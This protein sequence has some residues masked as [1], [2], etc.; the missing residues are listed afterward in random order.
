V[1]QRVTHNAGMLSRSGASR[2]PCDW[3]KMAVSSPTVR[4]NEVVDPGDMLSPNLTDD[5]RRLLWC[6]L[7]E[8]GGPARCT[9]EMAVAIGFRSVQDL[10]DSRD[11]LIG[12]I[13]SGE[14]LAASDWLR[15][16]LATEIVFASNA[17]GSGLDWSITTSLS[18]EDSLLLLRS[19]QRKLGGIGNLLGVAFGTRYQR[20]LA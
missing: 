18:D 6:G 8:W 19:I 5:E 11:R 17:I 20:P 2:S 14:P 16:L 4:Q 13:E 3:W 12:D 9:D 7:V 10:F 15:V 1:P